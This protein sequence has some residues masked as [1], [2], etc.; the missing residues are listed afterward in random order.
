MSRNAPLRE[1]PPGYREVEVL[2]A[3]DPQMLIRLNVLALPLMG[4]ALAVMLGWMW[5]VGR[6]GGPFMAVALPDWMGIAALI[7]VFP[8]HEWLHGLAIRRVGHR[9]RYG[10]I[11]VPF[12]EHAKLPV[13]LYA[14]ADDALFRRGEFIIVALAPLVIVT[15]AGMAL[16]LLLPAGIFISATVVVHAGGAIGDLWMVRLVLR[17]PA[18]AI[19]R[20][21]ADR[22]RIYTTS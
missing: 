7:A 2:V 6:M 4:A 18:G 5:L 19:V 14:T 15:L 1:L 3:T 8:L 13:A 20:D 21:E 11:T 17:Y 10:A 12:G 9:P 16:T 22:I